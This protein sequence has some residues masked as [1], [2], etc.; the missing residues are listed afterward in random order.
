M[1]SIAD[2]FGKKN[3]RKAEPEVTMPRVVETKP[4][5]SSYAEALDHVNQMVGT[6]DFLREEN[7]QLRQ[8][9]ALALMRIKDLEQAAIA[10]DR[11]L[12]MY[13]RYSIEV[14]TH[15]EHIQDVCHRAHEAAIEAGE[16]APPMPDAALK[17]V[18]DAVEQELGTAIKAASSENSA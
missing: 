4:P 14:R 8:D 3:G 15:L 17:V 18:V 2:Q 11:N 1:M 7:R 6:I 5:N 13:R 10:C 9:G 16:S 12:E